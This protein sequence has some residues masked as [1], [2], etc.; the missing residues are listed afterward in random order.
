M[1]HEHMPVWILSLQL[2]VSKGLKDMLNEN[3]E[4]EQMLY[5]H[6]TSMAYSESMSWTFCCNSED[7]TSKLQHNIQDMHFEYIYCF[8]RAKQNNNIKFYRIHSNQ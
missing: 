4:S 2:S 5:C 3:D 1:N 6:E 8:L 7:C